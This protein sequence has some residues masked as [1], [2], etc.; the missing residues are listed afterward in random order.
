MSEVIKMTTE[1]AAAGAIARQVVA[2]M[3]G[4]AQWIDAKWTAKRT[5]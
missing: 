1:G 4:V 5:D 3:F 2:G